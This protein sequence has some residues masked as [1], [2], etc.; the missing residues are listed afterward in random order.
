[1]PSLVVAF[2]SGYGHT[3]RLVEAA[4]QG[5]ASVS[6]VQAQALDVSRIDESGW[7]RLEQAGAIALACPTYMAGPSAAFKQFAD[8]SSAVWARQ[9]WKDKLAGGM[10][11]S[12]NMSGDKLTTLNWMVNFAMQ[13][14]MV[15]VGTGL[16]PP[17]QPG[18]GSGRQSA[19]RTGPA[20]GRSRDCPVFWNA[21]GN[22]PSAHRLSSCPGVTSS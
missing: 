8:Q 11:C 7:A 10:T 4:V 1:M 14:G 22:P 9:G 20:A 3:L 18:H 2:H 21:T 19:A 6:G 16:M 17:G 13:H 15:W 12:L 5:A